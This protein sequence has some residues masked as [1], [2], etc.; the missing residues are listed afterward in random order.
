M[1]PRVSGPGGGL[2]IIA[3]SARGTKLLSIPG[4]KIRPALA[5]VRTSLFDILTPA[6]ADARVVDLFAGTG[7]VGLEAVS[8]GAASCL[9]V[10]LDPECAAVLRRNIA[11]LRFGARAPV[12]LGDALAW[13]P[14][15][16]DPPL[17]LVFV[18]PPYRLYGEPAT[19]AQLRMLFDEGLAPALAPDARIVAEHPAGDRL[20]DELRALVL[21]DRRRYGQTELSFFARHPAGR[22]SP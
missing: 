1:A 7:S 2:H 13:R 4:H 18:D 19:R 5:R 8:R 15:A 12:L 3:G 11:R 9:F 14:A 20:E 22:P 17:D 16:G 6:L 21:A 10:E